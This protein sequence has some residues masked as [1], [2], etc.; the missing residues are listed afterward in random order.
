MKLLVPFI[1][2]SVILSGCNQ[3][4]TGGNLQPSQSTNEAAVA[5]LNLGIAY[6]K[7]RDYEKALEKLD[8]ARQAD[9]GFSPTYNMLGLLYQTLGDN[10]QAE[11][12][13]KKGISLNPNDSSTLNN[14]GRFLCQTGRFEEAEEIFLRSSNNPLYDSPEIAITNAGTCAM[15]NDRQEDAEVYFRRA[16]QLNSKMPEALIQMATISYEQINYL[17]ARAYLQRYQ[18]QARHTPKSLWL[19]IRIERELGDSDALASYSLLLKNGFP[20]S[21]ETGLLLESETQ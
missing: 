1:F 16:L 13:F 4:T 9:P 14:Y 10:N 2:I 6:M 18:E 15:I 17:S 8:K 3:A 12:H 11:D 7:E 20:D 5:N 21:R 19:G